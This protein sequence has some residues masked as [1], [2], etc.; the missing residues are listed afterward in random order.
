MIR[1]FIAL[2]YFESYICSYDKRI[3]SSDCIMMKLTRT[4][5]FGFMGIRCSYKMEER[6]LVLWIGGGLSSDIPRHINGDIITGN[7]SGA[8]FTGDWET[9]TFWSSFRAH[10][11]MVWIIAI[12]AGSDS[13]IRND[14]LRLFV[15][16]IASL[17]EHIVILSITD[18]PR[19]AHW[20]RLLVDALSELGVVPHDILPY[21]THGLSN[22]IAILFR[23]GKTSSFIIPDDVPSDDVAHTDAWTA[24]VLTIDSVHGDPQLNT[25]GEW[26]GLYERSC[27]QKGVEFDDIVTYVARYS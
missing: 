10:C 2:L 12:D 27:Y 8:D 9:V 6:S 26:N 18:E 17:E 14:A 15:Y 23:I 7:H 3:H 4:R 25:S 20:A 22:D 13:W 1:V 5:I 24:L 11:D 21:R 16:T 19:H